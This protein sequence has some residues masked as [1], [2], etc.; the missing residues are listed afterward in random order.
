MG[1]YPHFIWFIVAFLCFL[2]TVVVQVPFEIKNVLQ[3]CFTV[4]MALESLIP[5]VSLFLKHITIGEK[6][7]LLP[8]TFSFPCVLLLYSI[9]MKVYKPIQLVC[10]VA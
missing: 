10:G 7:L 4:V 2:L 1:F 8:L 5:I 9:I 3:I 6:I